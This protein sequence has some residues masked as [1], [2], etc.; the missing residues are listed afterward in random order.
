M[1]ETNEK[2]IEEREI[3]QQDLTGNVA[4]KK[5]GSTKRYSVYAVP[6]FQM[7]MDTDA[8]VKLKERDGA[9]GK[10][11]T[12]KEIEQWRETQVFNKVKAIPFK[13]HRDKDLTILVTNMNEHLFDDADL[14][15]NIKRND[16]EIEY[17]IWDTPKYTVKIKKALYDSKCNKFIKMINKKP[18]RKDPE[19]WINR[20][21]VE[22]NEFVAKKM[23]LKRGVFATEGECMAYQKAIVAEMFSKLPITLDEHQTTLEHVAGKD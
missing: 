20:A 19:K 11:H 17:V 10:K 12:G 22:M 9:F 18:S 13:T 4:V 8:P 15:T 14:D 6:G 23:K 21:K 16:Y 2:P 7:K 3:V 5:D 1:V